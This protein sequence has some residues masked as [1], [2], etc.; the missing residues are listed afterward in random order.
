MVVRHAEVLGHLPS[1]VA[2]YRAALARMAGD[3]DGTIDHAR[4]ALEWAGPDQP[5]ERGGAAGMLAL[6]YWTRGDLEDAHAAWSEAVANLE[7]AGHRADILG[8]SV[9]LADIRIAQGRLHDAQ[10]TYEHGLRI[11]EPAGGEVLRG[12][13]DMHIG[14][15]DLSR[16]RN[17]LPSARR[18][19]DA[20]LELGESLGLPQSAYRQRVA[21]ARVRQ[22]EGDLD[23]A[24]ELL[25]E[26]ERR[27]DADFFPEV[28]PIAAVRAR[29]RVAQ[30]RL[31]DARDWARERGLSPDD[32]LTYL[33]EFEHATL[34]RLL[35]AEGIRDRA[36]PSILAAID[37]AERL[38]AAAEAGGRDGNVIDI[39][40][41]AAL[42]RHARGDHAAAARALDR[43]ASLAAPEGFVRVFLDEGDPMTALLTSAA[44]R[45]GASGYLR[46]LL[47]AA[48]PRAA[49]STVRQALVEPL[50]E[51]ELDVLRLLAGDLAGPDIARELGVS[52]NTLRSHTKNVYTKLDVNSRRAAVR[53]G[54]ELGLVTQA[55]R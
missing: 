41:V 35:L 47:A 34:A 54:A 20:S 23:A 40:V 42:A 31:V 49:R 29:V 48:N 6:A 18:H 26:A 4:A 7:R 37:L 21:M 38:A 11:G 33:H 3:V 2:L 30:G 32:A 22:A 53:R 25:D 14:L 19:L 24:I 51:R 12:S 1:A 27:Y 17:D 9:A 36:D 46:E 44:N 52:L 39:L 10:R 16:E 13:V 43:A 55:G 5:L 8:C 50:S 45:I 15:A 28:R